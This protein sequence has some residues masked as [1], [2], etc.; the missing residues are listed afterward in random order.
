MWTIRIDQSVPKLPA[1]IFLDFAGGKGFSEK[2]YVAGGLKLWFIFVPLYQSWEP[3][4]KTPDSL[5]WIKERTR[6]SI[7]LLDIQIG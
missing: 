2:Y 1:N 6:I 5:E 4:H 3:D 7:P